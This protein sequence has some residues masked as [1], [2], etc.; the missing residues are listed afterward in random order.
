MNK[1]LVAIFDNEM[2]ADEGRQA[3]RKLHTDG[4]ITLYATGVMVKDLQGV[5]SVRKSMDQGPIGTATGLAVGSLIGLLGGP[6]GVAVGAI[7]GVTVGAVRDF[8]AAGVGLD[9]IYEAEKHLHPGTVALVASLGID[10][11]EIGDTLQADGVRL[12]AEAYA[13]LLAAIV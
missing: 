2:A 9:F 5:V 6:V 7:T 4:D 12:F 13:K 8:W 1:M 3:L 10:P 11:G